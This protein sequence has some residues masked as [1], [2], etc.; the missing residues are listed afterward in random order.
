M[1]LQQSPSPLGG[2]LAARHAASP[3]AS[4]P[5]LLVD[6]TKATTRVFHG[7]EYKINMKGDE[8]NLTIRVEE[9]LTSAGG[10]GRVWSANFLPSFL[11]EITRRTGNFKT[12]PV[13]A[14]MLLTAMMS[15]TTSGQDQTEVDAASAEVAAGGGSAADSSFGQKELQL[16]T[17]CTSTSSSTTSVYLDLLTYR[18]LEMLRARADKP[19]PP[20]TCTSPNTSSTQIGAPNNKRYLILTYCGEFDKNH[21]PLALHPDETTPTE[22]EAMRR[23]IQQLQEEVVQLQQVA[24]SNT[25]NA[26]NAVLGNPTS[27]ILM[28]NHGAAA[29]QITSPAPAVVAGVAG[30]H[31][32]SAPSTRGLDESH[33]VK[34][35]EQELQHLRH[36]CEQLS[37]DNNQMRQTLAKAGPQQQRAGGSNAHPQDPSGSLLAPDQYIL[38]Q[39]LKKQVSRLQAENRDLQDSRQHLIVENRRDVENL[40]KELNFAKNQAKRF[41]ASVKRLQATN[42]ELRRGQIQAARAR[43]STAARTMGPPSSAGSAYFNDSGSRRP[44]R[45]GSA[46]GSRAGSKLNSS[47]APSAASLR[48]RRS[49]PGLS[50]HEDSRSFMSSTHSQNDDYNRNEVD[51]GSGRENTTYARVRSSGYGQQLPRN[52]SYVRSRGTSRASSVVSSRDASPASVRS[53]GG[54]LPSS[55]RASPCNSVRSGRGGGGGASSSSNRPL[56]PRLSGG[57]GG[58]YD[59]QYGDHRYNSDNYNKTRAERPNSRGRAR[60]GSGHSLPRQVGTSPARINLQHVDRR[61][62]SPA[63]SVGIRSSVSPAS[64]RSQRGG[65]QEPRSI[66]HPHK[67]NYGVVPGQPQ[68]QLPSYMDPNSQDYNPYMVQ[69]GGARG[70]SPSSYNRSHH[71]QHN[72][73]GAPGPHVP[74]QAH[75]AVGG[76]PFLV[77]SGVSAPFNQHSQGPSPSRGLP[78]QA[79]PSPNFGGVVPP[80]MAYTA[81]HDQLQNQQLVAPEHGVHQGQLLGGTFGNGPSTGE[82]PSSYR[83]I[84]PPN[85]ALNQHQQSNRPPSSAG[86]VRPHSAGRQRSPSPS[87]GRGSSPYAQ[88]QPGILQKPLTAFRHASNSSPQMN[89]R[90]HGSNNPSPRAGGL[91]A[92]AQRQGPATISDVDARLNALQNFLRNNQSTAP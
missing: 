85:S 60:A 73:V 21:Y 58:G 12:Y 4:S 2:S 13:F 26:N 22:P 18:D 16:Q 6:F 36:S 52:N 90:G 66:G 19:G 77:A 3:G 39:N 28:H 35:L 79:L 53:R 33:R 82:S 75:N 78:N 5:G 72:V 7:V 11:E 23:M 30:G 43:T 57:G 27:P 24:S 49:G 92:T 56:P 68:E 64:A 10:L 8:Q 44:S 46:V 50:P 32:P 62:L 55:R 25:S 61:S 14:K 91:N 80:P 88:P 47:Y 15:S 84:V 54:Q 70:V 38:I 65:G 40:K 86:P 51:A 76:V 71:Q 45:P 41:E 42:D 63:S 81:S 89:G 17:S 9:P 74:P 37:A 20:G 29:Q 31:H 34:R 67:H 1:L 69:P 83:R 59:T 48:G 87:A